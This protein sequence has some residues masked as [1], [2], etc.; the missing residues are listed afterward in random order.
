MLYRYGNKWKIITT[1]KVINMIY[2][3]RKMQFFHIYFLTFL[4]FIL[5]FVFIYSSIWWMFVYLF[6]IENSFSLH[7]AS[8]FL[9]SNFLWNIETWINY[10]NQNKNFLNCHLN[11]WIIKTKFCVYKRLSFWWIIAM[12]HNV[13]VVW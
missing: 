11:C 4:T 7:F 13:G 10:K 12:L 8:T 9:C 3:K 6:S 2:I 5:T 1:K